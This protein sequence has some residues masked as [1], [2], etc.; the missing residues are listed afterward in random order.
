MGKIVVVGG[1]AAGLKQRQRHEDAIL[2]LRLQCLKEAKL[3][4]TVLAVCHIMWEATL[5]TL[6]T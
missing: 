2:M 4:L 5:T 6:K 3:F 1:V